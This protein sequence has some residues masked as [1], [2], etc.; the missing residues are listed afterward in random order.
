MPTSEGL[1][2]F[3]DKYLI[4]VERFL[5][6]IAAI[7]ARDL[8]GCLTAIDRGVKYY[9]ST[10]LPWY[11]RLIAVYLAQMG[12]VR[13]KEPEKW[14]AIKGDFVVTK[15]TQEFCN[16]FIDQG[17]EQ[18]I[19][20]LK[21]FGALPGLTQDEDLMDRFITTFPHLVQMVDKFLQ[22]FPKYQSEESE[23]A[24]HQLQGN[25]SLRSA[26]NSVRIRNCLMTYC[27]GNLYMKVIFLRNITS[28][29]LIPPVACDDILHYP[30][31]GQQGFED[32]IKERLLPGSTLSIWDTLPQ[33]KLIR[34]M[35]WNKKISIKVGEKVLKKESS[36]H[37]LFF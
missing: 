6:C 18:E 27:Q 30:E 1:A 29:V 14:A 15:S 17:L 2:M 34:F 36:D 7:H 31:K 4:Q 32:L 35:T 23:D 5:T 20:K 16:L 25:L 9:H 28:S 24:Y 11:F 33:L 12:E 13:Q 10:D 19:K 21:K 3:L 26:L 22:G 8:E 37:V